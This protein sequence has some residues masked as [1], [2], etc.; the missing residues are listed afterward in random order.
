MNANL[1]FL[2]ISVFTLNSPH[3]TIVPTQNNAA[4]WDLWLLWQECSSSLVGSGHYLPPQEHHWGSPG[5]P[6][7]NTCCHGGLCHFPVSSSLAWIQLTSLWTKCGNF[8]SIFLRKGR[9]QNWCSRGSIHKGRT[10]YIELCARW[11]STWC[12][13]AITLVVHSVTKSWTQLKWLN[14]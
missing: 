1:K 7:L 9:D 3:F 8:N 4:V 10:T 2:S 5:Q 14:T 6:V 12:L 13:Y 11:H